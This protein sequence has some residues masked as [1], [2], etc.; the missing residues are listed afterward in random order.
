[1]ERLLSPLAPCAYAL[2]RA[3]SGLLFV[4]HGA[5]K[6]CLLVATRGDGALA[7]GPAL[8]LAGR[9]TAR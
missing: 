3:I 5:Q 7:L 4:C 9:G 8:G 2:L 1:M 6:L